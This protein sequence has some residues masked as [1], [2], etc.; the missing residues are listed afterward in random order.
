MDKQIRQAVCNDSGILLDNLYRI[1]Q[2]LPGA[3]GIDLKPAALAAEIDDLNTFIY[4]NVNN[5]VY[6]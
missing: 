2:E 3:G 5:A 4:K 6:R 1:A